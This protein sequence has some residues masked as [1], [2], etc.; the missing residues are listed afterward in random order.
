MSD[1]SLQERHLQNLLQAIETAMF[2][3]GGWT[4]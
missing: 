4:P 2:D 3:N 1:L